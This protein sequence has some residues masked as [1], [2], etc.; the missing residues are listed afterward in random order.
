MCK[1]NIL[2]ITDTT[3]HSRVCGAAHSVP[4][5]V[6]AHSCACVRVIVQAWMCVCV[7]A[8]VQ[9]ITMFIHVDYMCKN[10]YY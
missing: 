5:H 8:C 6:M 2:L 1:K 9:I 10:I 4:S 3:S 7:M